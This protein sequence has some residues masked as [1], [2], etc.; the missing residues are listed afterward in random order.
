MANGS[1]SDRSNVEHV[2]IM[3]MQD[4]EKLRLHN[5][6]AGI[7]KQRNVSGKMYMET[8]SC[9]RVCGMPGGTEIQAGEK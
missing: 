2:R 5:G 4:P 9:G 6:R 8:S 1:H 7:M 3:R